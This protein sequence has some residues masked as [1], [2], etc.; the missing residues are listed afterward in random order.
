M[1]WL[2]R[3]NDKTEP[4]RLDLFLQKYGNSQSREAVLGQNDSDSMA[5][6]SSL[7]EARK[8]W[9]QAQTGEASEDILP[10]LN[11]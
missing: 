1:R 9:Q 10:E 11:G 4:A 5:F 6:L 8:R 7:T 3:I 2:D